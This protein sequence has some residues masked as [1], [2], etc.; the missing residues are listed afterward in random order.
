MVRVRVKSS[1]YAATKR[2]SVG[3]VVSQKRIGTV[4]EQVRVRFKGG[5]EWSFYPDELER[6]NGDPV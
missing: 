6:L 5:H 4:Y 3:V 1:P 2:G